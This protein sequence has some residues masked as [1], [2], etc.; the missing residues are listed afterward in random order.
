[1]INEASWIGIEFISSQCL[2]KENWL[3]K[4]MVSLDSYNL[5]KKFRCPEEL[6]QNYQIIKS[7][8]DIYRYS[9]YLCV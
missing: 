9:W 8:M 7:E 3:E 5:Q 1:M 2:I 6:N 4:F